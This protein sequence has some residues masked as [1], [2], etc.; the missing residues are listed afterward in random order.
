MERLSI[1]TKKIL[2]KSGWTPDRKKDIS[3]QIKY[4]EDKGYAVFD[5][6]KD[7]LEQF[8]GLK[9]TYEDNGNIE[10]FIIDPKEGLGD[11]DRRHY[12]RFEVTSVA[13]I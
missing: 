7:V 6:V 3:S 11:L 1:K 10:D 4:L 13:L 9:F 2:E 5:C 12:K 8:D